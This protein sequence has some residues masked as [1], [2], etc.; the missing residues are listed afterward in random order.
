MKD[1][2]VVIPA[3]GAGRRMG[4][5]AKAELEIAGVPLLQRVLEPFLAIDDVRQ[6]VIALPAA[7]LARPPAWLR[8][9]RVHLVPGGAE[10]R[11]SVRAGIE[12]L[13]ADAQLI[14]IHDAARPLVTTDLIQR[15]I[16]VARLGAG[17]IAALPARD[18]IHVVDD[19]EHIV[20]TPDRA[21]LWHAQTPQAFPRSLI[22][23][24]H[25]RALQDDLP[26]TDDAAMVVRYGGVV[27]VVAGD[28]DNLKITVPADVQ[29]AEVLLARRP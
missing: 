28:P 18:T 2:G 6:I 27:R 10:R 16:A 8:H 1:V 20:Q 24:A 9:A 29:L 14:V 12:A 19:R 15:V 17:A 25:R 4:G 21:V 7:M 13:A 26:A 5:Q 23:A 22:E 3:G 11:D